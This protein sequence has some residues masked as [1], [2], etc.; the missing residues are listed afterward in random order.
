MHHHFTQNVRIQDDC[1]SPLLSG[2]N[3]FVEE[4]VTQGVSF[5]KISPISEYSHRM[6]RRSYE[7]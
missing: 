7:S 2:K 1:K 3:K 5:G 6:V 4:L